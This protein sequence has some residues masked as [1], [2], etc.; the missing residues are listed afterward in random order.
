VTHATIQ[1]KK[2]AA[3][4]LRCERREPKFSLINTRVTD[5]ISM[6]MRY[7]NRPHRF[8]PFVVLGQT[9]LNLPGADSCIEQNSDSSRLDVDAIAL[10]T[11]LQNKDVH[12][13]NSSR[14]WIA[15]E[16]QNTHPV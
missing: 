6:R 15:A 10:A 1:V 4:L 13:Q 9:N 7:D 12:D 5:V 16:K 14:C 3:C 11:G 8:K 2:I